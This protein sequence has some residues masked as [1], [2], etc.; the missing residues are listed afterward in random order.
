MGS[1]AHAQLD[2]PVSRGVDP[3][4]EKGRELSGPAPS[5]L[6]LDYLPCCG[7]IGIGSKFTF[8]WLRDFQKKLS[9]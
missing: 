8:S 3:L 4:G 6:R 5:C 9:R 1:G 2:E 7:P